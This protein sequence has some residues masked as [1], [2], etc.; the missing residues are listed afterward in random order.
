MTTTLV[1]NDA[2]KRLRRAPLLHLLNPHGNT[3]FITGA[4]IV[5]IAVARFVVSV[6]HWKLWQGVAL[7]LVMMVLPLIVKVRDDIERYGGLVATAGALLV[8]QG[9]HTTEHLTQLVQRHILNWPVRASTGLLSPA[10]TEWVHFVWN[11]L[12]WVMIVVLI[13][14]G[15]RNPFAY[16]LLAWSTMHTLE[17]TYLMVRYLQ[18]VSN[19]HGLGVNNVTAQGLPGILGRDGWLDRSSAN[20]G[21][22]LCRLPFITK[23]T[24]L[25][26][27]AMWNTG[28]VVFMV[29]AVHRLMRTRLPEFR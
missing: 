1:S 29:P 4:F 9:L 2:P 23:A 3:L 15:M 10:N 14:K 12:V 28:E 6:R 26:L 17:H 21:T 19:L 8:L 20:D 13:A 27:H 16:M 7:L 25:D 24:R 11:W 18:V 22:L 5:S